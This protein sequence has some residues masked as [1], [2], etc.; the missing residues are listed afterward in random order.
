MPARVHKSAACRRHV[1][2]ARRRARGDSKGCHSKT[3]AYARSCDSRGSVRIAHSRRSM[4]IFAMSAS[5]HAS[6]ASTIGTS[7]ALQRPFLAI[8]DSDS[9]KRP[10]FAQVHDRR[11]FERV[12]LAC[13]LH[14][15][16]IASD[17]KDLVEDVYVAGAIAYCYR[18][19]RASELVA[20]HRFRLELSL[21]EHLGICHGS[22][23]AHRLDE[24]LA[25]AGF[26]GA[27]QRWLG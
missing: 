20:A 25:P 5:R 12:Q 7:T 21:H 11:R 2:R 3:T 8:F 19:S 10:M 18:H 4:P 24:P 22:S 16:R 17:A 6:N 14:G 15:R 27:P 9:Q 23:A 13:D 26:H 1:A